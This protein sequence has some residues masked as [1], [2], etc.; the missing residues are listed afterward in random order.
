VARLRRDGDRYLP[1]LLAPAL[2]GLDRFA[3]AVRE[4]R[5]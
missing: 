5:G 4:R 2:R 1:A 3:A